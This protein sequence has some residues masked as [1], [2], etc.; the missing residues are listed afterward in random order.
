MVWADEAP[1]VPPPDR[2]T[3]ASF[4][5]ATLMQV[6]AVLGVG[7]ALASQVPLL[8]VPL[9]VM[10]GIALGRT[11]RR[12]RA[13]QRAGQPL[14]AS[15]Q[16]RTFLMTMGAQLVLGLAGLIAFTVVCFP[17]GLVAMDSGGTSGPGMTLA[18][19]SGAAAGLL[20]IW[21]TY[22]LMTAGD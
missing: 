16:I 20:A 3:P 2:P 21:G 8:G 5:L 7:L 18:L 4:N 9:L 14:P 19:L 15:D 13:W 1:V 12:T 6:V 10:A 11:A 17:I 22:R